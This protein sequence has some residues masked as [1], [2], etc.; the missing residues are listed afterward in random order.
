[1]R[2]VATAAAATAWGRNGLDPTAFP[3]IAE[4]E[5]DLVAAAIDLPRRRSR[6]VGTVT[7]GAPSRM[8]AVLG[9]RERWRERN[10]RDRR[11][12]LLLPVTAHSAFR[13]AAHLF[14]LDVVD[15]PV[16]E[17]FRADAAVMIELMSE[18]DRP[19]RGVRTQLRPRCHRPRRRSG[20]CGGR[21]RH[22]VPPRSVHRR[23]SCCR[24]SWRTRV[25]H[26]ST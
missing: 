25:G 26:R 12:E 13:K 10:G 4:I 2:E 24:S 17:H 11:P 6:W 15:V 20:G 21:A 5:N 16:D 14:D 22:P 19:G 1:M 9:A 3:S 7:S 18:R 23:L 8:L